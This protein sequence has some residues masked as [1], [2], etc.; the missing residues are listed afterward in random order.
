MT[1][2]GGVRAS[3]NWRPRVERGRHA[4]SRNDMSRNDD[5]T[6]SGFE[7]SAD[8][9]TEPRSG[10]PDARVTLG[11]FRGA[12]TRDDHV[13]ELHGS[14]GAATITVPPQYAEKL[15]AVA[16][17]LPSTLVADGGRRSCRNCS[18]PASEIDSEAAVEFDGELYCNEFCAE[19][20]SGYLSQGAN[21][22]ERDVVTDGG[23]SPLGVWSELTAFQ[24]DLLRVL[25]DEARY[26]LAIK[27][28]LE[29]WWGVEIHHGRLY[30]NLD[31]L[32]GDGLV[33]KAELDA[34]TNEYALTDWGE[35]V[36]GVA[37][38]R[39]ADLDVVQDA[40]DGRR[41]VADGG[42]A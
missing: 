18:T 9:T 15:V 42:D 33:V 7:A 32:V 1:Q 30:P 8:T 11:T 28:Q 21:E 29:A 35:T 41:L 14:E 6:D 39:D 13:L 34:R 36:L 19:V 37:L 2:D 40:Q 12:T 4:G 5:G 20:A 22:S 10:H 25:G 3:E 27:E 17:A 23:R 31:T 24:R 16:D 38:S 26:G